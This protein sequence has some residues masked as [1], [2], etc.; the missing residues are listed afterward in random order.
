MVGWS[1]LFGRLVVGLV[2][3]LIGFGCTVM[4]NWFMSITTKNGRHHQS[5]HLQQSACGLFSGGLMRVC[6]YDGMIVWPV[7]YRMDMLDMLD[8]VDGWMDGWMD[9]WVAIVAVSACWSKR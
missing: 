5:S 8:M 6:L 1:G 4:L 7:K 9:G 2:G 3:C